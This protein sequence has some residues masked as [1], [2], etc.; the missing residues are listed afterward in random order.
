MSH[1]AIPFFP[2]APDEDRLEFDLLQEF[3][4]S[5]KTHSRDTD[6]FQDEIIRVLE[7]I[8]R[9]PQQHS[10]RGLATGLLQMG[11]Y[12]CVNTQQLRRLTGRCKSCIN[13]GLQPL[14]YVTVKTKAP[15]AKLA[16]QF[17]ERQWT[18]RL[19]KAF[20]RA[21]QPITVPRMAIAPQGGA[22]EERTGG[23]DVAARD[24]LIEDIIEGMLKEETGNA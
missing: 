16:N 18:V 6:L 7:F 12:L 4:N 20:Q 8:N 2:P 15:L 21:R 5:P 1:S 22:A 3:F 19:P 24:F 13:N 9:R 10:Q 17:A 11:P 14:G 23:S